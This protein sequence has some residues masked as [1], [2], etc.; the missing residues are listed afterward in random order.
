[1]VR[2]Y[3]NPHGAVGVAHEL[4]PG[5]ATLVTIFIAA[6]DAFGCHGTR[7]EPDADVDRGW[8]PA[9]LLWRFAF[10]PTEDGTAIA[11]RTG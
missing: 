5:F 6:I 11:A 8:E 10:T 7:E 1:V 2:A 3:V 4:P 9:H